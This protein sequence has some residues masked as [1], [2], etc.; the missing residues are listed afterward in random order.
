MGTTP[1]YLTAGYRRRTCD[2]HLYPTVVLFGAYKT[3]REARQRQVALSGLSVIPGAS[4]GSVVRGRGYTTWIKRV[5]LGDMDS[6]NLCAGFETLGASSAKW[7][8]LSNT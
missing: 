7:V 2:G 3:K 4:P 6:C 1:L 5:T 8:H